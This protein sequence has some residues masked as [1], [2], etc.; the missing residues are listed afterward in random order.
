M[1]GVLTI[2]YAYDDCN[3]LSVDPLA[4]KYYSIS[5]YSFC[6]NNPV[7]RIDKDGREWSYVV[8]ANGHT[9]INVALNFS[10]AGN[11]TA[12]QINAYKNAIATQFN[13]TISEVSGGAMSGTITFYEGNQNIVQTLALDKM[14]GAIGGTTSFFNSSVN[15]VNKAGELRSLSDVGSD[16][17]HEMLHTVRLEHPFETTQ[18]EDTKLLRVA[19]NSFVS[20]PTTDANIVNNVMNYPM[21]T[22]DGQKST[23]QNSL[24]KGQLNFMM[25]EINLQNQG[26]G[27][28][29]KYNPALTPEQNANL[30][31]QYYENYWLNTPGTPVGNK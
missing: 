4:E 19:P 6:G 11:Y 20:T 22:I 28:K 5:P 15:L 31:K 9:T 7:N 21:I 26:Y 16:A 18:T 14:D 1:V 13:S 23:N 12:E 25:N 27:F 8:D 24:T 3:W 30:Y 10:V 29:P 2:L 17:T